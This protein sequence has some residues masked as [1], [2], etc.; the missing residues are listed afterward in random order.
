MSVV[1][2][3]TVKGNDFLKILT[4]LHPKC[5]PLHW[6]GIVLAG[7]SA[8]WELGEPRVAQPHGLCRWVTVPSPQLQKAE[9]ICILFQCSNFWIKSAV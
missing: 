5:K 1:W 8:R 2:F 6:W 9:L 7:V 4:V 3:C